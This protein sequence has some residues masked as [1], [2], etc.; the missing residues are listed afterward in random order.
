MYLPSFGYS[1]FL[2]FLSPVSFLIQISIEDLA[3][4][5]HYIQN[6][7]FPLQIFLQSYFT[8]I[9]S[10]LLISFHI[11]R[12]LFVIGKHS[13]QHYPHSCTYSHLVTLKILFEECFI[14][15]RDFHILSLTKRL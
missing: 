7:V 9:I 5:M 2:L 6:I 13:I 14:Y 12:Q 8:P 15:F 4:L 3:V 11:F 10:L 1:F